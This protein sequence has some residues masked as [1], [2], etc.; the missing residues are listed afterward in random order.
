MRIT[1]SREG[2][3]HIFQ[4]PYYTDDPVKVALISKHPGVREVPVPGPPVEVSELLPGVTDD[5][6]AELRTSNPHKT[7]RKEV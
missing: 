6:V 7:S 4:L 3:E 5:T 1:L 2:V